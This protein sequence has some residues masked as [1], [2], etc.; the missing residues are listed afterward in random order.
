[1]PVKELSKYK[2]WLITAVIS[3]A[4]IIL[5]LLAG[6]AAHYLAKNL[7][8]TTASLA[9][10][11]GPQLAAGQPTYEPG[12]EPVPAPPNPFEP[13]FGPTL[14]PWRSEEHTSELQS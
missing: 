11:A 3:G 2:G 9:S 10:P 1:M 4:T 12:E 6:I 14:T 7:T 13:V 8:L 5:S